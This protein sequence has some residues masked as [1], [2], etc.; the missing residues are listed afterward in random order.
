MGRYKAAG[1]TV[2]TMELRKVSQVGTWSW[3]VKNKRKMIHDTKIRIASISKVVVGMCAI[4]MTRTV[5]STW[6]P[7]SVHIGAR[8]R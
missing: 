2:A 1:V 5:S 7:S 3:S 6:T 8:E 4:A